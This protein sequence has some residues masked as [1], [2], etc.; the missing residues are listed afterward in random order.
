VAKI[1]TI[2]TT[3][4]TTNK[5]LAFVVLNIGTTLVA[6]KNHMIDIQVQIGRKT[7][8]VVLLNGQR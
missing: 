1:K 7:I 8:D 5:T 2:R 6:I 4:P 3:K